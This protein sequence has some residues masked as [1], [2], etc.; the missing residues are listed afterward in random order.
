MPNYF[1]CISHK[2]EVQRFV[3]ICLI[4]ILYFLHAESEA[5]WLESGL[6]ELKVLML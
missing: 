4:K 1:D 2:L 5:M 6:L 3:R